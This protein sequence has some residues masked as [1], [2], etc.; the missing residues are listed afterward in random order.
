MATDVSAIGEAKVYTP[1]M[2]NPR[3]VLFLLAIALSVTLCACGNKGPLVRPAPD[4][5]AGASR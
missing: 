5:T 2:K 3:Y 1:G 4:G